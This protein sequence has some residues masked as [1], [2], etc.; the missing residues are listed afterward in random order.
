MHV[1]SGHDR[2]R[3]TPTNR[4]LPLGRP[5]RFSPADHSDRN[6]S[7]STY[8]SITKSPFNGRPKFIY[9]RFCFRFYLPSSYHLLI[10]CA[11]NQA[12]C[13]KSKTRLPAVL[14]SWPHRP[15]S[16]CLLLIIY[17][18]KR[19]HFEGPKS[20][21]Q[22]F[23]VWFYLSSTYHLLIKSQVWKPPQ[24]PGSRPQARRRREHHERFAGVV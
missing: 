16:S 15:S 18:S 7:I 19:P 6:R 17:L 12:L 23:C 8:H 10:K 3:A 21:Y 24:P 13:K 5:T 9:L 22:R 1:T 4:P 2:D 14:H 20:N 11:A